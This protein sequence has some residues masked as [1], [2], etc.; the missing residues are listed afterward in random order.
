MA[1]KT[2]TRLWLQSM[3]PD[4]IRKGFANLR[5]DEAMMPLA[6]AASCRARR[7]GCGHQRH[8]RDDGVQ[9]QERRLLPDTGRPVQT[10][11][12]AVVVDREKEIRAFVPEDYWEVHAT[13][14]AEAG[15]YT[16]R[17]FDEGF[18]DPDNA[19][20]RAERIWEQAGRTAFRPSATVR[21]AR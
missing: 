5:T 9:L 10:P 21:R 17:W 2:V 15:E 7:T 20:K 18:K 4:A 12:L 16:G 19:H 6:N 8:T 3:T 1:E 13:F 14:Q 11:T